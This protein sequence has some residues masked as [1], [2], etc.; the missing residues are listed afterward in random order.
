[1]VGVRW[2]NEAEHA[3]WR[4]LLRMDAA[5]LRELDR[6][7]GTQASLSA[8]DYAVLV[9]LTEHPDGR[10]RLY[11]LADALGWEKSR[12]SHHVAR[13]TARGLVA[14]QAC[15]EDHRGA[16]VAVTP[17]GRAAITAAAPAHVADVRELFVDRL[18]SKQLA[19]IAAVADIV[20]AGLESGPHE[21]AP[22]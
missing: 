17:E 15:P 11:Q 3:A 8:Q 1:M 18:T 2:L 22:A 14:K 10:L 6:R 5:L 20:L 4:G 21:E 13:M 16:Y 12:L 9:V 19:T 7:L